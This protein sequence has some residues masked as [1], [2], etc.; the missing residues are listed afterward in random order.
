MNASPFRLERYTFFNEVTGQDQEAV[1]IITLNED[2]DE[3]S[4]EGYN[5]S[6]AEE[7]L[8]LEGYGSMRLLSLLDLESKLIAADKESMKLNA[9]RGWIN[10]ILFL[11]AQDPSPKTDWQ[12]APFAYEETVQDAVSQLM[13]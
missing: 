2:G 8:E 4:R 12:E 7:W 10:S 6:S 5:G 9:V 3:V 13:S 11:Y 1:D